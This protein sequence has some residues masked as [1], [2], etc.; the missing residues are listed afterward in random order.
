MT[1]CMLQQNGWTWKAFAKR[2]KSLRRTNTIGYLLCVEAEKY[3][4]LVSMTTKRQIQGCRE[5]TSNH[6][7]GRMGVAVWGSGCGRHKLL[8]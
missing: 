6:Q 7:Y 2:N 8:G 5:H 1:H 3:N 4:K